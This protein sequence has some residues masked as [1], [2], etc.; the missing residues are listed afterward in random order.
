MSTVILRRI[1]T[2]PIYS[3]EAVA[4]QRVRDL[5]A[6]FVPGWEVLIDTRHP[7]G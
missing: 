6:S 1:P 5:L 7:Y 3:P 4:R 2:D